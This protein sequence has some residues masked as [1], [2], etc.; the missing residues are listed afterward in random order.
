MF[1][2]FFF[3]FVFH[4]PIFFYLSCFGLST[5]TQKKIIIALFL[6]IKKIII[7]ISV[8]IFVYQIKHFFVCVFIVK[9]NQNLNSFKERRSSQNE[10]D[11]M[12]RS[13][14]MSQQIS[15]KAS[16]IMSLNHVFQQQHSHPHILHQSPIAS[17][18]STPTTA[19][20]YA[21]LQSP[22]FSMT[23]NSK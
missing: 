1:I 20:P 15:D 6:I 16:D 21:P 23:N 2:F 18:A 10:N 5:L 8:C 7:N 11:R 22:T 9:K 4:V 3:L 14:S 12:K 19:H 13:Q 17:N